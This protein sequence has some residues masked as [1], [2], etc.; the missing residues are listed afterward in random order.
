MIRL[1]DESPL[2]DKDIRYFI[3]GLCDSDRGIGID[4]EDW[5]G[6]IQSFNIISNNRRNLGHRHR[7]SSSNGYRVVSG[8]RNGIK[9]NIRVTNELKFELCMTNIFEEPIE[10]SNT[11]GF[12][13]GSDRFVCDNND[14]IF[15]G[16]PCVS[17]TKFSSDSYLLSIIIYSLNPYI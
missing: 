12:R 1:S 3:L 8:S 5:N 7:S 9:V 10:F 17:D 2:C 16:L 11:L 4:S 13:P 6:I 14:D 15:D